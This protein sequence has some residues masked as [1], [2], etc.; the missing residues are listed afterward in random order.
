MVVHLSL[1]VI[2][3]M[4]MTEYLVRVQ[5]GSGREDYLQARRMLERWDHMHLGWVGTNSPPVAA[6][7]RLCVYA[8]S[9]WLWTRMPLRIVYRKEGRAK[10]TKAL[11][12]AIDRAATS[13][14]RLTGD[15]PPCR[16]RPIY[17]WLPE[18]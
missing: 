1:A 10:L 2:V 15:M 14:R 9:L 13:P 4:C 12:P 6:G 3:R 5:V 17:S 11:Q 8:Q 7:Q 16:G 18:P